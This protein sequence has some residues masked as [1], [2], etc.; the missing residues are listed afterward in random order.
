MIIQK[1]TYLR[2]VRGQC[3]LAPT[4]TTTPRDVSSSTHSPSL[5]EVDLVL[6]MADTIEALNDKALQHSFIV[7][8]EGVCDP[9]FPFVW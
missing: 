7:F 4:D 6:P 9:E 3:K 2:D 8:L 5:H 1:G